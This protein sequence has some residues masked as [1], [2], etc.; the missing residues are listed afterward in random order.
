M[1]MG[2]RFGVMKVD[3]CLLL[4]WCGGSVFVFGCG[5]KDRCVLLMFVSYWWYRLVRK[6][7]IVLGGCGVVKEN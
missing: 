4:V 2:V 3:Y 5:V 1:K 7:V 6:V